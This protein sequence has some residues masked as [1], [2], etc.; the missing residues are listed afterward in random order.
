MAKR[1]RRKPNKP[2]PSFPLTAHPNGQWCKKILGKVHF[3][4][5]WVEPDAAHQ[6]YLRL[7]EDLHAGREPTP[8]AESEF[9][10]KELGNQFLAYQM[11]RVGTGQIGGRWFEDCRRVVKQ[12]ARSVGTARSVVSMMPDDFQ[13][14]RRLIATRGLRGGKGLGVHAIARTI[15]VIQGMF[16]WGVQSGLLERLPRYGQSFAKPSAADVR[17]SR[18]K[19]ER[20]HGKKLFTPEQIHTLLG[21]ASSDLKAA[22]LLG[23]NGGFGNTDCAALPTTAVDLNR[24]VIDFER[25]KT[26]VRRVVPLWPETVAALRELLAGR[27]PTPA[28]PAAKSLVFRS[29]FGFPLVRQMIQ[30]T[31]GEEIKK[32][33]YIDRLGDR[34]NRLLNESN[35]KRFG[36]GFYTLRHTFRTWADDAA[37]Q[38]AIHR[39]MGH[40]IPGMSGLYIE[41]ISLERL[42]RVTEHVR[43]RLWQGAASTAAKEQP[44]TATG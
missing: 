40:S 29:E 2:F 41:D 8:A 25:P 1:P 24:A 26:A 5:V 38:H 11:Q 18:A 19:R 15:V 27:R 42:K 12:F 36:V 3:F 20:E 14:Y 9:T 33:V 43:A 30:R 6:N 44:R 22:I 28:S 17:R 31:N 37:D 39:V 21:L 35:L 7:A 34:F 4:G 23:I 10:I 32:V 13:Q 16:K